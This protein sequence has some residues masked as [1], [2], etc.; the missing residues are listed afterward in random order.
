M[1]AYINL[2][3]QLLLLELHLYFPL[4]SILILITIKLIGSDPLFYSSACDLLL[5][6][7][8]HVLQQNTPPMIHSTR[9]SFAHFY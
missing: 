9:M 6:L 8:H 1:P 7:L 4:V 5:M 2:L 3:L